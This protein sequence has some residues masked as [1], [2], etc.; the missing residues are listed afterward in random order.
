MERRVLVLG[1]GIAGLAAAAEISKKLPVT[2]LEAT[3]RLGGRIHTIAGNQNLPI[4]LGAEFVHGKS[5]ALW[6]LIRAAKL[7]THTVPDRHWDL[8]NGTLRENESFWDQLAGV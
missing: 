3:N 1:G 2:L 6:K 4:E 7:R 8:K 5:P